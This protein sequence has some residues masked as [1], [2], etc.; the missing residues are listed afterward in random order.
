MT[1][2]ALPAQL[3]ARVSNPVLRQALQE[4]V[5]FWGGAFAGLF[6][7]TLT[8]EPLKTWIENTSADAGISYQIAIDQ[9]QQQ[10]EAA[11]QS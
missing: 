5:A 3:T 9:L 10:R 1:T 7:L 2:A 11:R 8:E 6:S 4:P